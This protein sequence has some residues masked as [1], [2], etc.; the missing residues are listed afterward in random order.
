MAEVVAGL[1]LALEKQMMAYSDKE[2]EDINFDGAHNQHISRKKIAARTKK[3]CGSNP[4]LTLGVWWD[5]LWH[6]M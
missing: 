3:Y 5:L 2:E 1:E 4:G 6:R